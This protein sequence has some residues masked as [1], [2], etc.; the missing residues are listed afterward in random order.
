[1]D[2]IDVA[3]DDRVTWLNGMVSNDVAGLE[4][5]PARS[6]CHAALLTNRGAI[7]ADLH[8][9][10]RED[11][12]WMLV[13]QSAAEATIAALDRF[14]V[15][16][17]VTL[18]RVGDA[19]AQWTLEGPRAA[20]VLASLGV[21]VELAPYAAI[22]AEIAGEP[23]VLAAAGLS[24]EWARRVIAPAAAREAVEAALVEAG[25]AF[26]LVVGDE[27]ALEVL[28]VEAGIPRQ[29]RELDEDVLP[30]EAR[31]DTAI[32]TTKGCYVGQEIVAR[33]RSRGQVNHL[34]VGLRFDTAPPGPGVVLSAGGKRTGEITSVA[35]SPSV[36]AIALGF[37]RREHSEPGTAVEMDGGVATV[38]ALPF[39]GRAASS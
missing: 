37:V 12:F 7:I 11:R 15:A 28:R 24:G 39:V 9:L 25:S 22:V 26:G 3:G 29:G 16:D 13:E 17:D 18:E 5:G 33:L 4:P 31:L 14:I 10:V 36:G 6:G 1:M 34:L 23:V 20:D 21:D 27:A 19:H 2:V 32:S 8:V 30:D 38:S 35:E